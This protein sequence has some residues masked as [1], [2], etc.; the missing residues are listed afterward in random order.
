MNYLLD[1][2]KYTKDSE[3]S[4]FSELNGPFYTLVDNGKICVI[5]YRHPV[6]CQ[7]FENHEIVNWRDNYELVYANR[8]TYIIG[9]TALHR[10]V[11]QG[12]IKVLKAN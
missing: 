7:A 8:T 2:S 6:G 4:P 11:E 9:A 5:S 1:K 10:L 12:Q 3:P